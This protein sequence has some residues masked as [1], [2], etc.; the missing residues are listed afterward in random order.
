MPTCGD[1][2]P[3]GKESFPL[4]IQAFTLSFFISPMGLFFYRMEMQSRQIGV[5]GRSMEVERKPSEFA[6]FQTFPMIRLLFPVYSRTTSNHL[7]TISNSSNHLQPF[8]PPT[9]SNFLSGTIL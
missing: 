7:P 8:P 9:F 3:K 2:I 4:G 6:R 5:E 1:I